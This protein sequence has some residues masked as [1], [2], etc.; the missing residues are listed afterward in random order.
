MV[1]LGI[2]V[3]WIDLTDPNRLPLTPAHYDGP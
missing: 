1:P 3:A 2:W